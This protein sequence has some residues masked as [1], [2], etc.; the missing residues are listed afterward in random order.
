MVVP[1]GVV[2]LPSTLE[3]AFTLRW[4]VGKSCGLSSLLPCSA[5]RIP[6]A[7]HVEL[8]WPHSPLGVCSIYY[9]PLL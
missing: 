4:D 2:L 5:F 9:L 3:L 6:Y 8:V 7:Y 1:I